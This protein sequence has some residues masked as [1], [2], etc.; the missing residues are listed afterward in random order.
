MPN[1]SNVTWRD[2]YQITFF[3]TAVGGVGRGLFVDK[4]GNAMAVAGARAAGISFD[5]LS[6][7]D[8]AAKKG[9]PV[10][11]IGAYPTLTGGA[12]EPGDELTTDN[13][14]RAVAAVAGNYVNG[15]AEEQSTGANQVRRVLREL[16]KI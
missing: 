10:G 5:A 9:L 4:L 16:Y 3:P 7:A 14:G 12:F 13:Q 2:I 6:A 15:I 11:I 8:V 1:F